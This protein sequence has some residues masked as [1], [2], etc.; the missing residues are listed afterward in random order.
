VEREGGLGS[1][2]NFNLIYRHFQ[3]SSNNS[4]KHLANQTMLI[5][6]L[7]AGYGHRCFSKCGK[8]SG[9]NR[10]CGSETEPRQKRPTKQK[11]EKKFHVLK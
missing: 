11:K 5:P 10:V 2:E 3:K 9:F 8:K 6:V 7:L 4:A 1:F